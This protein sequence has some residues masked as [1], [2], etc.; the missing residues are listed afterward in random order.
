M[1]L[2][3]VLPKEPNPTKRANSWGAVCQPLPF[4]AN[5][6]RGLK[7]GEGLTPPKRDQTEAKQTDNQG[8]RWKYRPPWFP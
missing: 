5:L 1:G 3:S 2:F 4:L 6:G 8:E 7:V